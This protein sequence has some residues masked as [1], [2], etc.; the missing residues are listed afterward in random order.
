LGKIRSKQLTDAIAKEEKNVQK[1]IEKLHA[2]KES[3]QAKIRELQEQIEGLKSVHN[4]AA[5]YEEGGLYLGARFT[6]IGYKPDV[7]FQDKIDQL[8]AQQDTAQQEIGG[9]EAD[10]GGTNTIM[11][12]IAAVEKKRDGYIADLLQRNKIVQYA[13]IMSSI[14]NDGRVY[15]IKIPKSDLLLYS[16]KFQAMLDKQYDGK[17]PA[18]VLAMVEKKKDF[19]AA[20][21]VQNAKAGKMGISQKNL[22]QDI[23]GKI[24]NQGKK[25]GN[26]N[27]KSITGKDQVNIDTA[28]AL[29]LKTA[30]DAPISAADDQQTISY[31][32]LGDIIQAAINEENF[33]Q[34]LTNKTGVLIGNIN[35]ERKIDKYTNLEAN[36]DQ[37]SDVA[38]INIADIPINIEYFSQ[39]FAKTI[40]DKNIS[41]LSLMDFLQGII[42]QLVIPAL[43]QPIGGTAVRNPIKCRTS[44]ITTSNAVTTD[45]GYPPG[46]DDLIPNFE[47]MPGNTS[48][49]A[50]Q[51][52]FE[53]SLTPYEGV[54]DLNYPAQMYAM[55]DRLDPNILTVAKADQIWTYTMIHGV[56]RNNI[57][58]YASNYKKDMEKGIYHFT[59]GDSNHPDASTG[60]RKDLIKDIKF[61]KVKKQG[62]REMMIE[63]QM[64]GGVNNQHLELWSIFDVQMT[65][66]GN[67]LL[68]PGKHIYINPVIS[69]FT[70]LPSE[71]GILSELGLGGY[72]MV[73]E[74]SNEIENGNWTTSVVA[75]WQ[76][77]GITNIRTPVNKSLTQ[78]EAEKLTGGMSSDTAPMSV[79]PDANTGQ[80]LVSE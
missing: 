75:A 39:F 51:D 54:V 65:M 47:G 6:G 25:S 2:E 3:K 17:T 23:Y 5:V 38:T 21:G 61:T 10:E 20:S 8:E 9:T 36:S 45:M 59:F 78:S 66:I 35:F 44:F 53:A 7:T 26:N 11:G 37:D 77:N 41:A 55:R 64:V 52:G 42:N 57:T 79:E 73:T 80:S 16:P 13:S 34:M 31:V 71:A 28:I 40:I 67:N 63:R 69:G 27:D 72:Y 18:E 62:Q 58:G 68:A 49:Y 74:V 50:A 32:Y 12:K 22:Q 15:Q 43:N 1:E 76:S 48:G 60:G 33:E 29:G 30:L 4:L 19:A 46:T 56:E 24:K 14:I 70:N